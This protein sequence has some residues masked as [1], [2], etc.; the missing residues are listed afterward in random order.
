M[1]Y[2]CICVCVVCENLFRP[3]FSSGADDSPQDG[4]GDVARHMRGHQRGEAAQRHDVEQGPK[5]KKRFL[6]FQPGGKDGN[7]QGVPPADLVRE[8]AE[9]EA[10]KGEAQHEAGGYYLHPDLSERLQISA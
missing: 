3:S 5:G 9:D 10:T 6:Q 4:V 2:F 8:E 1:N 7:K